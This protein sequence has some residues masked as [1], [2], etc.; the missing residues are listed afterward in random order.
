[1]RLYMGMEAT[2]KMDL[3]KYAGRRIEV[4]IN[5]QRVRGRVVR[6]ASR[7]P[8]LM[9]ER[10][11]I[12]DERSDMHRKLRML[13]TWTV[14]QMAQAEFIKVLPASEPRAKKKRRLSSEWSETV[15]VAE[16]DPAIPPRDWESGML[17]WAEI[18]HAA[19][20]KVDR[21]RKAMLLAL[22]EAAS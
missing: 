10:G 6:G 2:M 3:E 22:R 19:R 16:G 4:R 7:Q 20:R 14:R 12:G 21:S 5:K 8:V 18:V 11:Q 13:R 15:Q 17:A 9:E 1:M